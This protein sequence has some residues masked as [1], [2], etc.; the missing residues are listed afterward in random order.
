MILK[1][2]NLFTP[3]G[4]F[5]KGNLEI[6]EDTIAAVGKEI[7]AIHTPVFDASDCYVLPGFLDIHMHGAMGADFS[8]GTKEAVDTIAKFQLSK[9]VTGFLGTTLSLPEDI[10]TDCAKLSK[11]YTYQ[12]KANQATFY[13]IHLEGPFFNLE[14]KGAQN[15]D[16]IIPADFALFSRL[17]EASDKTIQTVSM[18][19]EVDEGLAFIKQAKEI[20]N[21]SLGHTSAGY[22]L[23]LAAFA[24]GANHATHLF[25]AMAPM[26][27]RDPAIIGAAM[28][29]KAFVEIISD[30]VH[31]HP[32][33]VRL[34]FKLYGDDKVCLISDSMRA[35][36]L[37]DGK[38]ELGAQ[39]V[40]VKGSTA[41][42]SS[43]TIAGSVTSLAD[44]FRKAISFGIPLESAIKAATINPAKAIGLDHLIG[45][46]EV[47]KKADIIIL[48]KELHLKGAFAQGKLLS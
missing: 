47:G 26:S 34:A 11:D 35:C 45:S 39:E 36:G 7:T 33:T 27:H 6:K 5:Q 40:T 10:L 32:A 23:A 19:P 18:A 38:Y 8:D 37:Q 1:N 25:N 9:G 28:D 13:G 48:D 21:V 20:C 14:K 16:Y 44:C 12:G 4:H 22:D 17:F 31:L 41:T 3:Q 30:G 42:L 24:A 15:P 43:G 29:A 2:G 46:L